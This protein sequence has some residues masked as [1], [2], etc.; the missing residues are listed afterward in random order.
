MSDGLYSKMSEW[1]KLKKRL[2]A[3]E[4]EIKLEIGDDGETTK[5]DGVR[6][7]VSSKGSYDYEGLAMRLEPDEEVIEKN[8]KVDWAKVCE[9]IGYEEELKKKFYKVGKRSISISLEKEK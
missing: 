1:K 8:K 3:L 4:D 9:E 2:D 6:V 5:F 7:L